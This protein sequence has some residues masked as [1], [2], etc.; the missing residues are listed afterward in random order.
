MSPLTF[1]SR[2]S[3][4]LRPFRF[5]LLVAVVLSSVRSRSAKPVTKSV[6]L[7]TRN[8]FVQPV[9]CV[10]MVDGPGPIRTCPSCCGVRLQT[11]YVPGGMRTTGVAFIAFVNAFVLSGAPLDALN[12]GSVTTD[13]PSCCLQPG[14]GQAP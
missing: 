9:V 11:L 7:L 2:T 10:M 13:T 5:R 1:S 8:V 4:T 12:G 14:N 3:R 6:V